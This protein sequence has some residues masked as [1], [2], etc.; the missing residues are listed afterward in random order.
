M[1][2][3]ILFL[4]VFINYLHGQSLAVNIV[5]TEEYCGASC[6][7]ISLQDT[8]S[9][10]N[11]QTYTVFWETL[12]MSKDSI[13]LT[14]TNTP[15]YLYRC[16]YSQPP[17]STNIIYITI[18][19]SAS[20]VVFTDTLHYGII[21]SP[22]QFRPSYHPNSYVNSIGT[23]CDSVHILFEYED[24]NTPPPY[25][26]IV[27]WGDGTYSNP[28]GGPTPG[29]TGM[30]FEVSHTYASLGNYEIV[31]VCNL[32]TINAKVRITGCQNISGT[33]FED[34]NMNCQKDPNEPGMQNVKVG[35]FQNNNLV[36]YTFSSSTGKYSFNNI[37]GNNYTVKVLP[38]SNLS[39]TA[40]C[41][42][43]YNNVS[44]NTSGLD[45][46]MNCAANSPLAY[47]YSGVLRNVVPGRPASFILSLCNKNC[48]QDQDTIQGQI[49]L[50]P[51][52]SF[53]NIYVIGAS[54]GM[55]YSVSGDTISYTCILPSYKCAS[56]K[57]IAIS[58]STLQMGDTV[59]THFTVEN[60]Y[61]SVFA[62]TLAS[63]DP[64]DKL[65]HPQGNVE[66][67]TPLT[68][69]IRFQNT[70]NAPAYRV[71]IKDTISNY[72]DPN[73]IT[74]LDQ[75]HNMTLN[76]SQIASGDYVLTFIDD[77]IYLPDSATN[78]QGSQG[79]VTFKISPKGNIASGTQVMNKAAIY[80]DYNPPVITNTVTTTYTSTTTQL[81]LENSSITVY[82][83]PAYEQVFIETSKIQSYKLLD[84]NGKILQ[85]GK[86]LNGK[87]LIKL[88]NV[89]TGLYILQIGNNYVKLPVFK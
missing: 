63:W 41:T 79:Y 18:K 56:I 29:G 84:I 31:I 27:W 68:Y 37:A 3:Y 20:N 46:A 69:T 19:D 65:V 88:S 49:F 74:F 15:Y 52:L 24:P 75:S 78:P 26:S 89:N 82:P 17:N 32:D 47:T 12:Y 76:I 51:E 11:F 40:G 66:L 39:I 30:M 2:Y 5:S 81:N 28:I 48:M 83:I 73:T 21:V 61:D 1:K 87:N 50:P 55:Y 67:G 62:I 80:F 77:N 25:Q 14:V 10:N 44:N 7:A 6:F 42:G 13:Q 38:D 45:F 54:V 36:R 57:V 23:T 64:N 9:T 85:T 71:I 53:A 4:L 16:P 43:T 22:C 8:S 72:L 59:R 70:G 34:K 86:V 58:D 60:S 33:V 35:L